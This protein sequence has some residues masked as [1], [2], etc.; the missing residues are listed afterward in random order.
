MD[1][2]LSQRSLLAQFRCGVLPTRI[3]TGSFDGK[4]KAERLCE[5]CNT[6]Y[7]ESCLPVSNLWR[8]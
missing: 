2:S 8:P 7:V 6:N 1:L 3:E 5:F 4:T